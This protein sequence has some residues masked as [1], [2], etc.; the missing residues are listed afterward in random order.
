MEREKEK[1]EQGVRRKSERKS[2]L[3]R[4]ERGGETRGRGGRGTRKKRR[5]K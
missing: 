3:G 5:G 4:R 1:G 2:K